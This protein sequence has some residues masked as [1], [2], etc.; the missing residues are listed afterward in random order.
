MKAPPQVKVFRNYANYDPVKFSGEL[1][2]GDWN[3]EQDPSGTNEEQNACVD[4]LWTC[5]E[6]KF[7][8]VAN[9]HAPHIQKKVRGLDNCPWLT[10][11][12]KKNIRQRESFE[13]GAKNIPQ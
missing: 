2:R 6:S 11:D 4:E 10:G 9:R 7:L 5:F 13:E 12:I 8:R 3:C 1:K